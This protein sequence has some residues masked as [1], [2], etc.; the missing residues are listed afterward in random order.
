MTPPKVP[1][2]ILEGVLEDE[3]FGSPGVCLECGDESPW[4]DEAT[5][6]CEMCFEHIFGVDATLHPEWTGQ[7]HD[8]GED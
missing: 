6:L 8:E 2:E 3:E 7:T 5:E 4:V 1:Q